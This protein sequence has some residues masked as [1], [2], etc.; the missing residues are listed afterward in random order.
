LSIESTSS[1]HED[2]E[3]E[4]EPDIPD[5]DAQSFPLKR[6]GDNKVP[7]TTSKRAKLSQQSDV[8]V[9]AGLIS[10]NDQGSRSGNPLLLPTSVCVD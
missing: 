1:S 4:L 10:S 3:D 6:K 2:S 5:G 8:P 9:D 7:P